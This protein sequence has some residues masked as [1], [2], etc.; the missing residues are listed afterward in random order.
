MCGCSMHAPQGGRT[1][2][3]TALHTSQDITKHYKSQPRHIH[4][5]GHLTKNFEGWLLAQTEVPVTIELNPAMI[6]Y[7]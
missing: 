2:Q 7:K 1:T 4:S 6:T 3:H 5:K